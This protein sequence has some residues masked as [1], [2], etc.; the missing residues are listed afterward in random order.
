M[1]DILN[2]VPVPTPIKYVH[3]ITPKI[4][5]F[6]RLKLR[7]EG[8]SKEIFDNMINLKGKCNIRSDT[9]TKYTAIVDEYKK[10]YLDYFIWDR[11]YSD[12]YYSPDT[13]NTE[14]IEILKKSDL[15]KSDLAAARQISLDHICD[16][17]NAVFEAYNS[18]YDKLQQIMINIEELKNVSPSKATT[19][20]IEDMK[21]LFSELDGNVFI[22]IIKNMPLPGAK[23]SKK[24]KS[25]RKSKK[26]KKSKRRNKSK[27]KI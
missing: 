12:E 24:K 20:N 8:K 11:E 2:Q 25:K 13:I 5:E 22:K 15:K 18:E 6:N 4:I 19:K 7:R 27:R 16:I 1:S 26:R 10:L 23:K 3:D 21:S 9:T 17:F 14:L